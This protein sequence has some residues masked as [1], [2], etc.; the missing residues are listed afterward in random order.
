MVY[1]SLVPP[2]FDRTQDAAWERVRTVPGFLTEREARFLMLVAA[3]TPATGPILEIGS[4]KGRSTVALA[5]IAKHYGFGSVIAV[6]PHTSPSETD[7]NLLGQQTS[8][9]EFLNNIQQADVADVVDPQRMFSRDYAPHAPRALRMLWIDGDHTLSG[10]RE[11]V[12]L[13]KPHLQPGAFIVMHDVLGRFPGSLRVFCEDILDSDDFG[14]AGF[15]G[16][17]GWAQYLPDEGAKYRRSR[18]RSAF[19]ARRLLK[20]LDSKRGLVGLNKL[21][22]KVHRFFVPHFRVQPERWA[23]DVAK[24]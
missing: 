9:H 5:F 2:D 21:R 8:Y 24:I 6:D 14:P 22:Y 12:T 10:V 13:F 11:D 1:S 15:C 3:C 20:V 23:K 19:L 7:P 16:S 17:I 18:Q 4:F